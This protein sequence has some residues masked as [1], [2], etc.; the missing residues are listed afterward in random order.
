MSQK[1]YKA[2]QVRRPGVLELVERAVTEP[3]MGQVRIRIEACGVCHSD[4]W[5]VEGDIVPIEYPRVPGHEVVG[6]IEAL[7]DGVDGWTVGQRIG[8][9]FLAGPCGK[10][11][12]CRR[13]DFTRCSNQMWTGVHYDGGYAE[14]MLANASGLIAIPD[15]LDAAEAAPLLCAGITVHKALKKSHAKAGDTIAVHGIG[16][17]GHLAVQFARKMGFRTIAISRGPGKEE[18][19]KALGAHFYI[20]SDA[21]DPAEALQKLGGANVILSTIPS[22]RL[23]SGLIGGLAPHGQLFVVGLAAEMIEVS[24]FALVK[25]DVSIHGSLTGTATESEVM[26]AFSVLENI[27][28]TIETTPLEKAQIAYDRMMNN[29]VHFRMVLTTD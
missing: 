26:L 29:Q 25:D 2:V 22:P 12:A 3:A 9:G 18:G 8:I 27:R 13:G 23:M 5:T 15:E 10:C 17:L 7:G 14:I 20:D 6:R 19:A 1:Y 21:G 28:P 16:G 4:R 11:V 24:P